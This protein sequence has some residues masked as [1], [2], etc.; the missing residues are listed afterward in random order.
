MGSWQRLP[1]IE[2]I[3]PYPPPY[4][5]ISTHIQRMKAHLEAFGYRCVVYQLSRSRYS[6]KNGNVVHI[7][8]PR[9]WF[10]KKLFFGRHEILHCHESGWKLRVAMGI[11][12]FFRR[13]TIITIHG[14]SLEDSLRNMNRIKRWVLR[15]ALRHIT[16]IITVNPRI[17]DVVLSLGV[18]PDRVA[19]IP[20]FVLPEERRSDIEAIPQQVWEFINSH[21]PIIAANAYRITFFEGVDLYGIDMC[22]ELCANLKQS[23]PNIGFIFCLP[24]IGDYEYFEKM[25]QRIVKKGIE[26]NFLFQTKPCQ[27]YPILMK[28][29][30]F[31]RSTNTDG[32][33]VSLREALCFKIPSIAS[34]AAPRPEGVILFRN[35]D[36]HDFTAKVKS[37]LDNYEWY[38]KR[39][40]AVKIE[41]NA[42]K[43]IEIYQRLT[44]RR[45]KK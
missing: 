9:K 17:R 25:K 39:V 38:K 18:K 1:V 6:P 16:L 23:Y 4:G 26:D 20:A 34:D 44:V 2:L 15:M 19:V 45:E 29:H 42:G 22:I 43:L 10:L 40:E 31:V 36:I 11:L 32:D 33:A 27:F 21:Y 7:Y 5:G 28:S 35:R 12:G 37:V 41:S 24:D 3:G 13:K 14:S 30:V 8:H